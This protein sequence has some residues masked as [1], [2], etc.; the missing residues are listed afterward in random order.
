MRQPYAA[1]AARARALA[2]AGKP[3]NYRAMSVT[4]K[5]L[6]LA[7][8][9]EAHGIA[10]GLIGR[11]RDIVASL[12]EPERSFGPLPVPTRVGPFVSPA[13]MQDWCRSEGVCTIIDASHPFD[14]KISNMAHLVAGIANIKYL[15][16]L[17]PAWTATSQDRWMSAPSVRQAVQSLG[18]GARVFSNTG[19]ATLPDYAGFKGEV[20]F[21]RQTHPVVHPSPY[22]FLKFINGTPPF[23]QR[24]EEEL[25]QDLQISHL[26]CRN[27]GG[28]ASMSKLLAA[29]TLRTRVVM[30]ARPPAPLGAEIAESVPDALAW[31]ANA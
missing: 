28:A 31:E 26:I 1:A 5:T 21:L 25:F 14:E 6:V 7:G 18:R 12:P 16:V 8:A 4:G 19:W 15:R 30:I 10:K 29:R 27:V 22:A 20:I 11:E 17:R 23:S 3:D 2:P 13:E 9:R 24:Q